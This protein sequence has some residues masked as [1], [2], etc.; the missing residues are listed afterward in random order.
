MPPT[1]HR[2]AHRRVLSLAL[3]LGALGASATSH[4]AQTV[5][6]WDPLG[7]SGQI[8]DAARTYALVMRK[9][10]ADIT[11]KAYTDE[12]IAADDFK[13]GQCQGLLATSLRTRPY[14]AVTAALDHGGAATIIKD[15]RVDLDASYTVID[16]AIQILAADAAAKLNI[17]DG[18]EIAGIVSTG[19]LYT[20]VRDRTLF[21]RGF[22][23]ARMPAFDHDKVQAYLINM[24]GAQPVSADLRNFVTKFNNGGLDVLFA[25]AVAFRAMEIDKGVGTK[26]G[27]SRLPLGFTTL[28]LVIQRQRFP[29]GFGAHSR[30]HWLDQRDAVLTAVR[31]AEADIPP[32]T[33]VDLSEQD[34]VAFVSGQHQLRVELGKRGFYDKQGLRFMK[35]VRCSVHAQAPDCATRA[36]IDW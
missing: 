9:H 16:K 6:V 22:A 34:A 33:W 13:V 31:K 28:Q 14:N 10:G 25:P 18:H 30:R 29:E 1:P 23:G 35:R 8:F 32:Q 36:E 7:T 4:A 17:Q 2:A 20:M 24:M 26:G 11:V 21:T 12:R 15:G 27:I 5:C 19:A 3:A